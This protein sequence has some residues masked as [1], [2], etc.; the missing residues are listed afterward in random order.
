MTDLF[1]I[2]SLVAIL[3]SKMVVNFQQ[4]KKQIQF[5]KLEKLRREFDE[6]NRKLDEMYL[7][8]E[9]MEK[10]AERRT[11]LKKELKKVTHPRCEICSSRHCSWS[12]QGNAN[13]GPYPAKAVKSRK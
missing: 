2:L 13:W 5:D 12:C 4:Q 7:L 11:Q 9:E 1:L 8:Q 10:V 3:V 6:E